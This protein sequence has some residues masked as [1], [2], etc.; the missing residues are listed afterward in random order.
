MISRNE[1]S[2]TLSTLCLHSLLDVSVKQYWETLSKNA[3]LHSLLDVSVK[4]NWEALSRN[5]HF[6]QGHT[7][8]TVVCHHVYSCLSSLIN[9]HLSKQATLHF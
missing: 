6:Y 5:G 9:G 1:L 8:Q 2:I 4:V 3:H 7:R